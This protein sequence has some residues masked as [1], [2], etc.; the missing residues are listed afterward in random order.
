[1]KEIDYARMLELINTS[2]DPEAVL[3][4]FVMREVQVVAGELVERADHAMTPDHDTAPGQ[5]LGEEERE[6]MEDA[7]MDLLD[8]IHD[9]QWHIHSA[10]CCWP[11][12]G[13]IG[14]LVEF[15]SART[16]APGTEAA[17]VMRWTYEDGGTRAEAVCLAA[18]DARCRLEALDH[19]ECQC[20]YWGAV[21]HDPDGTIWHRMYTY[22]GEWPDDRAGQRHQ[23]KPGGEC[24]VCLFINESGCAEELTPENERHAF[25]LA[26]VAFEPVWEN[27]GCSWRPLLA[28]SLDP[29]IRGRGQNDR[30]TE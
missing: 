30:S 2:D 28:D 22:P 23:V 24:Q 15:I 29:R 7:L 6:A 5:A 9:K 16:T 4:A 3:A 17:H 12:T 20:E 1:M 25:T 18:P 27:D 11:F 19:N 21:E 8:G 10:E 14:G 13:A 26:E